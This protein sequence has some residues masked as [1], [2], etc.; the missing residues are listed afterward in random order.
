MYNRLDLFHYE[1]RNH[2]KNNATLLLL[3]NRICLLRKFIT[4]QIIGCILVLSLN[5]VIQYII[6]RE[7]VLVYAI[8]L[9]FSDPEITSHYL[10]NLIVQYYLMIAGI[11]GFAAAESVLILFVT[12]VAGYADVLKNKIDE[13]NIILLDAQNSRDR[14][15]VKLKLREIVLLH[16][17]VLE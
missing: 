7:R 1:Y 10:L 12:S 3:M 17:R 14:T 8:L 4:L 9:P 2:E 6:K 5:P 11:G 16:Q 13:M 15:P